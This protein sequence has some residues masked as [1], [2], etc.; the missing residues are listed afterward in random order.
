MHRLRYIGTRLL[1]AIPTVLVIACLNFLLLRL[2]PG[3]PVSVLAGESGGATPEYL[4]QLRRTFGLDQPLYVQLVLYLKNLL[5]L[6]L[7]FSYRLNTPVLELILDRL[8][9]TLLLMACSLAIAIGL[10]MLLGLVAAIKRGTWLDNGI[11]I[12]A[13]SAYATPSFWIGLML[14]LVFSLW[15]RWFPTSGM[16]T[17]VAFHEG[18]DRVWDIAHHLVLP[19][20]TLSLFY[21][22]LYVRLMRSALAEQVALDYVTTA[23]A[24]GLSERAIVFGHMLP[25]AALPVVTMAGVQLGN[26]LGGSVVVE[27]V[28]S[29]PGLGSLALSALTTRDLNLL[30]GIFFVSACLVVLVNIVIDIIYTVLDPRIEVS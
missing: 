30:L 19:A 24:K 2:A 9:P 7:G 15:L 20:V 3:D 28:F 25:N 21:L 23:R 8:G 11:S 5:S 29:W 26:L 13:L 16:E 17:I 4:E 6:N 18:W 14:I 22:A 1:H 12:A 27:A 10:G